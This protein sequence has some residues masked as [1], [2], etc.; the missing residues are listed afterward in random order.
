MNVADRAGASI[1]GGTELVEQVRACVL[2]YMQVGLGVNTVMYIKYICHHWGLWGEYVR[3]NSTYVC[4][5]VCMK[6]YISK[7]MTYAFF[8]NIKY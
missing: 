5:P 7:N 6:E 3:T 8:S 4:E 2:H 1:V